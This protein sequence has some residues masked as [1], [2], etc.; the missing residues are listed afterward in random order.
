MAGWR[1]AV[2]Q[3]LVS[4]LIWALPNWSTNGGLAVWLGYMNDL[5]TPW[6]SLI[7]VS[8]LFIT[9]LIVIWRSLRERDEK[10]P[11]AIASRDTV[12][13]PAT[14]SLLRSISINFLENRPITI[15]ERVQISRLWEDINTWEQVTLAELASGGV[16]R[17]EIAEVRDL[18]DLYR[19]V[20]G[21]TPDH[22][23]AGC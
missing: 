5:S 4:N 16:A 7:A 1:T 19:I 22:V 2:S 15:D 17:D 10:K 8:T 3:N 23:L 13:I 11:A 14:W 6:L 18:G 21:T 9:V 12:G 20:Q